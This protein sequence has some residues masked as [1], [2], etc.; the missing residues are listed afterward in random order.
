MEVGT[1]PGSI[2]FP[3]LRKLGWTVVGCTNVAE[4][5]KDS[6]KARSIYVLVAAILVVVALVLS[7]FIARNITRPLQQLRDSMARV[8][9]GD[10]GAAE[11]ESDISE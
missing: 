10:F 5:L 4:L 1:M 11:V 9:E 7:N 2:R 6:K 8:Q 3:G